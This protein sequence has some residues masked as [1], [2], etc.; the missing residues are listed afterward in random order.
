MRGE[1]GSAV[2]HRGSRVRVLSDRERQEL[3]VCCEELE[4]LADV[5]GCFVDLWEHGAVVDAHAIQLCDE[6][7]LL[8]GVDLD[9]LN[10]NAW[11]GVG[12]KSAR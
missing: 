5:D 11:S 3:Y 7:G 2:A 9:T 1:A 10:R 8:T 4:F 6:I 12:I